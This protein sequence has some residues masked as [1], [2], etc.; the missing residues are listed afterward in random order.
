[1]LPSLSATI[2]ARIALFTVFTI[3]TPE[4]SKWTK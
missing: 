3:I 1:L 2:P 4:E